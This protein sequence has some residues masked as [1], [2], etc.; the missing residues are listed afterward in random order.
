MVVNAVEKGVIIRRHFN[1]ASQG[2]NLN[3]MPA[4]KPS[5]NNKLKDNFKAKNVDAKNKK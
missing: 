1:K 2:P 5:G 3:K 4:E